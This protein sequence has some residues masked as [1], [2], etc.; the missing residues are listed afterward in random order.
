MKVLYSWLNEEYFDKK[1]PNVEEVA[2]ALLF[3]A[4]EIEGIDEVGDGDYVIDVDVLPNRAHDCLSHRGIAREISVIMGIPLVEK[5]IESNFESVDA[6][7]KVDVV[8]NKLCDRFNGRIIKNL[9]IKETPEW[10]RYRLEALGQR[11]INALVDATNYVTL[12]IG[13]PTHAFDLNKVKDGEII[14]KKSEGEE[15]ELLGG[16]KVTLTK[17]DLIIA[18]KDGALDIAGIKGGTPAE[19][20]S[21]TTDVILTACHF[22]PISIRKTSR[23]TNVLTDASKRF[24]NTPSIFL[25][26][27]G[28]EYLS[29]LVY[30]MCSSENTVVERVVDIHGAL[31]EEREVIFSTPYVNNIL[32]TNLSEED[33]ASIIQKFGWD[34]QKTGGEFVLVIPDE[35]LDLNNPSDIAEEIGRIWGYKNIE[36]SELSKNTERKVNKEFY[37]ISKIRY[38]LAEEGFS[39]VHTASFKEKGEL[40][41]ANPVAKDRPYLRRNIDL[42]DSFE[43]NKKNKDL[44]GLDEVKI[45]EIGKVFDKDG[46]EKLVLSILSESKIDP[47]L[48]SEFGIKIEEEINLDD[49]IEKLP[50]EIEEYQF[51]D[52]PKNNFKQYSQY[53]F[54]VRDIAVWLPEDVDRGE[55]LEILKSVD[56]L[57]TEPRLVDEYKK[58]GRV[59]YAHRLVFQSN[60]RTL[61]DVEVGEI[62][63]NIEEK[64]KDRGWEIR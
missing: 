40:K 27:E 21:D 41:M 42:S 36:S 60:E 19:V 30:S 26:E 5:S 24:E 14:V 54:I 52:Y 59:S 38:K 9:Q 1:L 4:F 25:P 16:E 49:A 13:Q 32:G 47:N 58:E 62:M 55:L 43:L 45:F 7:L 63:S 39:E 50:D 56:L 6:T 51:G 20:G 35:R 3:H 29:R 2:D 57:V 37:Y 28:M 17:E 64:I 44:L 11:S 18:S 48:L 8:E 15:L 22:D 12:D 46:N 23:R 53:P 10:I 33:I 61:T 31:P 34:Y